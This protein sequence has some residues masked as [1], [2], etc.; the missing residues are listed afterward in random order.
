LRP[1]MLLGRM[2]TE[3]S[4]RSTSWTSS[5]YDFRKPCTCIYQGDEECP[6]K[7]VVLI[8]GSCLWRYARPSADACP[9]RSAP[10]PFILSPL[11]TFGVV[12]LCSVIT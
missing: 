11:N 3:R 5:P 6:S 1:L 2:V 12:R 9:R 7:R 4:C 8:A 10:A